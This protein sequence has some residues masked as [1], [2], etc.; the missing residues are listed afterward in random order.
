MKGGV[1]IIKKEKAVVNT[2]TETGFLSEIRGM[3]ESARGRVA[4]AANYEMTM[5]Y[6]NVGSRI[7]KELLKEKRAEY[8]KEILPTLSAKLIVDYGN[9]FSVPNL[10]RMLRLAE[11]YPEEKIL[12]TLSKELSWSH[13]VEILPIKEDLKRDYYAEMCRIE[14]WSVFSFYLE[15]QIT[16]C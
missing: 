15:P 12:S 7:R 5:L 11:C 9:G 8:G 10:S 16:N 3:I 6:W 14:R 2:G 4:A 1:S 13:I